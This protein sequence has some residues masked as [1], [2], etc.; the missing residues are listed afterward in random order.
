MGKGVLREEDGKGKGSCDREWGFEGRD[1]R[2]VGETFLGK[3]P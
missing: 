3:G 1:P 2:G